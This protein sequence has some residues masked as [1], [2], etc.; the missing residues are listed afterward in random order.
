MKAA[1]GLAHFSRLTALHFS[2]PIALRIP[3]TPASYP[4]IYFYQEDTDDD[5]EN[6]EYRYRTAKVQ[7]RY[8]KSTNGSLE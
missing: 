2:F 3:L 7:I 4:D 6:G 5:P 1:G 8:C